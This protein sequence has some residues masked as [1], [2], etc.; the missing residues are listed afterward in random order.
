MKR[1]LAFVIVFALCFS[2]AYTSALAACSHSWTSWERTD[3]Y[4]GPPRHPAGCRALYE[5]IERFCMNC[6][7][8]QTSEVVTDLPHIWIPYGSVDRCS[9]CGNE[10]VS[11]K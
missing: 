9:R 6:G 4:E 10:R 3:S 11:V 1:I 2:L 7:V 5:T 8:V